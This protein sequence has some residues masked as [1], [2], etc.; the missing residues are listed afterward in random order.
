MPTAASTN[1]AAPEPATA[2]ATPADRRPGGR[3][4]LVSIAFALV[5][6]V[7]GW[8]LAGQQGLGELGQGGVNQKLL[9]AVG[10]PAPNIVVSDVLGNRVSLEDLR[11]RPVWLNFWGSW[12]APCRAEMPEIQEAYEQLAPRGVV[13]LAV[14]L[15]EPWQEAALFA[16][17]N[18]VTFPV[19]T[20]EFRSDTGAAYPIYNF[21]THI[22]I[23]ADGIVRHVV[24]SIMTVNEA[25]AYAE[26]T[27]EP[28]A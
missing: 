6:V 1:P 13:L 23:D 16:A 19:F 18:N 9:P 4:I 3:R 2:V 21:P 17:R 22:F 8:Y 27:M 11:G 20:D 14:S 7:G 26:S 10:E 25:V 24:L 15:D 5:I 12:C 28:S